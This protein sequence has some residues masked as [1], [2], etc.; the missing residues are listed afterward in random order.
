MSFPV[1][2]GINPNVVHYYFYMLM[3]KNAKYPS[4]WKYISS[5]VA[6]TTCWYILAGFFILQSACNK[7]SFFEKNI[8]IE[9]A[10]W[11][12]SDTLNYQFSITDTLE[13]YNL[14]IDFTYAD[15]FLSQNVYIKL[16]TQFPDGDRLSKQKSFDLFDVQGQPLGKC[17][18]HTCRLRTL[19]QEK[20][21]FNRVG[22][23]T[24]T[25]EQY[26]R[27]TPLPGISAVGIMIEATGVR[28]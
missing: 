4:R 13:T 5:R 26:N 27:E 18:G 12:Y 10:Q 2:K 19:L 7:N 17:S 24:I 25:L 6:Q 9:K 3:F 14:Y 21:F 22:D 1:Q 11:A 28:R 15:T 8:E 20:A 16:H 23:Y